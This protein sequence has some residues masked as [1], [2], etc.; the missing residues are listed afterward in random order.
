MRKTKVSFCLQPAACADCGVLGNTLQKIAVCLPCPHTW[1]LPMLRARP[2][3]RADFGVSLQPFLCPNGDYVYSE[4]ITT[5]WHM[6]ATAHLYVSAA[7][8][9][10]TNKSERFLNEFHLS[11]L[12]ASFASSYS[13][14]PPHTLF[15]FFIKNVALTSCI[16]I[17][18]ICLHVVPWLHLQ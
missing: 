15:F 10:W 7:L 11:P 1:L 12:S 3:D 4:H 5:Y 14:P 17:K 9:T 6:L 18:N 2:P 16:N 8:V 13:T